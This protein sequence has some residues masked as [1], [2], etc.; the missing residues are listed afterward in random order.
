MTRIIGGASILAGGGVVVL[1]LAILPPLSFL[2]WAAI[3]AGLMT[4]MEGGALLIG[5]LGGKRA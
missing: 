5:T 2:Q 1:A 4:M 3:L